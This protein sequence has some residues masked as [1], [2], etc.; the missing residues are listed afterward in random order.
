MDE[1]LIT[2]VDLVLGDT[3]G[4]VGQ[5]VRDILELEVEFAERIGIDDLINEAAELGP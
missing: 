1:S 4:D 2:E 5:L 3:A